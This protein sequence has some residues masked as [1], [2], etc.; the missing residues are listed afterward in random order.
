MP[1]G[2]R[3]ATRQVSWKAAVPALLLVDAEELRA[4]HADPRRFVRVVY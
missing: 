4:A 1:G 3:A 2:P